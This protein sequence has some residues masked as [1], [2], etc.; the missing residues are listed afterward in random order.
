MNRYQI[1]CFLGLVFLIFLIYA[2]PAWAYLDPGTGS[3]IVQA[4]IG[5]IAGISV[6][7]C[8]FW[9]RLKSF[10]RR[11]KQDDPGDK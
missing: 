6:S 8:V 1:L 10:F 7:A 5:A 2:L 9:K 11:D 4:I 3:M